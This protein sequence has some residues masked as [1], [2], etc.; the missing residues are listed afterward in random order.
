MHG[1]ATNSLSE[2]LENINPPS[3]FNEVSQMDE[4]TMEGKTLCIDA[5]IDNEDATHYMFDEQIEEIS[6]DTDEGA[7]PISSDYCSDSVESTPKRRS[8]NNHTGHKIYN[9]YR[10]K[11]SEH[12]YCS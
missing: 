11:R 9:T 7:T 2:C 12:S 8:I 3:L 6:N 4:S 5:E 10:Y 1:S